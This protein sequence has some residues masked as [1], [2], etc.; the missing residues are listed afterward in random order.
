MHSGRGIIHGIVIACG[1]SACATPVAPG[2]VA[3]PIR[4]Q[5]TTIPTSATASEP[6]PALRLPGDVHPTA[7]AIELTIDPEHDGF[8]GKADIDVELTQPRQSMWLHGRGLHVTSASVTPEGGPSAVATWVDED[9][10]G[11]GR[12]SLGSVAPAGRAR[13]HI[14]YDA[15]F[16]AGTQGLFK[17][18]QAGVP[19][20]FTQFEAI[21]ARRAFPCFDEPSFKIPFTVT[22]DVPQGDEV[23]ANTP[24][25]RRAAVDG[26]LVRVSFAPTKPLPSYL[27]AF[28]VGPLDVV[29]APDVPPNGVRSHALPLRGVTTKGRGPELAYALAHVGEILSALEDYFGIE[30][31]YDKMDV[32]AVPDMG[33][34]MEN[35]GAVTFEED[36]LL[37]DPKTAPL[38]QRQAF[39]EVVA[40]EFAH[41]WFGDL[42][43][44][45]WW[46]DTWLNESFAEW[47]GV[48]IANRWDPALHSDLELASGMQQAI[49][50]DSLVNA[51]QIHQPIATSDDIENSFD[52]ATYEKGGSVIAMF[53]RWLGAEVFQRGVRQHLAQHRFGNATVDDF[54]A[55]L[56]AAAGRDIAT[57]YRTFLDQPGVPYI[58]AAVQCTPG[59]PRLHLKQSRFLPLGSTGDAS[60]LW[61]VPV[62][63]RYAADGG[64]PKEA[65]TLLTTVEG[66]LPLEGKACPSWVFPN[67]R[68]LGYYR[69]ALASADLANVRKKAIPLL[70]TRERMALGNSLRA[71][72]SHGTTPFSEVLQ[73]ATA[74]ASDP[75]RHVAEEPTALVETAY[76]WLHADPVRPRIEAFAR[77]LMSPELAKLGWTKRSGE[78]DTAMDLRSHV[79]WFLADVGQHPAVRTEAKRRAAAYI[80]FGKD[81]AI[82]RDAVDENLAGT[83]LS[84]AGEDA[85]APM[86]DALIASFVKTQDD[87][88]RGILLAGLSRVRN[89]ALSGRVLDLVLDDRV[90]YTEM[91]RPLWSQFSMPETR[92]AAWKWLKDHWDAVSTRTS[93]AMFSGV[94]LLAIPGGFCDEAHAQ[95]VGTFLGDRAAKVDGG[96]RV[97]AKTLEEIHLCAARRSAA[98]ADA[99]RF[100]ASH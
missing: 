16:T 66:D 46:D 59:S 52:D 29:K 8:S 100:F 97:L 26:G 24:E 79:L 77:T 76:E 88:L 5:D 67:A 70:D 13:I 42:V 54:L 45:A 83:A 50:S 14:E 65:C 95:D 30:Y 35:A 15:S 12:L 87:E 23:V 44:M 47:M 48:K 40:H 1:L 91:L 49:G 62:C 51:R 19:Y 68:G 39:A 56:S 64:A 3:A 94:Q 17:V 43:T 2:P 32:L 73:V 96:P 81:S 4:A 25:A 58:E 28:A 41:Q 38:H 92:D 89:P 85:D 60:K 53:E 84:V 33:G 61:Q 69:F 11:L 82:H 36:L 21:D 74:L 63:A 10:R 75:D 18:K 27:V 34:A 37:F 86:L 90:K 22:L 80:G 6:H 72:F 93:A 71:A 20:A 55:A 99:R 98:E 7:E 57:P 9:E 78:A 31:P